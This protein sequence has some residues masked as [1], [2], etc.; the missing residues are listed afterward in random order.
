[1]HS[2]GC[3]HTNSLK[4]IDW[5]MYNRIVLITSYPNKERDTILHGLDTKHITWR[6]SVALHLHNNEWPCKYK[7]DLA[8]SPQVCLLVVVEGGT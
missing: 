6:V 4:L 5:G 7:N 3:L 1:M 2:H 8:T